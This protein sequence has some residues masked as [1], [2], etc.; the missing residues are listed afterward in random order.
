MRASAVSSLPSKS[1]RFAL[2]VGVDKYDDPQV[3][4]LGG[5]SNDARQ[6]AGALVRH[7]GFPAD[8]VVLLASG[9]PPE[10]Q[11]TR[12]QILRRLSNLA[13]AVPAD[14][15]L[16][17]SF[18]GHGMERGG[19]A[20]L[21]SSD[22][23][24]NGDV[25]LL[26]MTAVNA[27]Q[28]RDRIQKTGVRQVLMLLDACR[29]DPVAARSGADNPLTESLRRAFDFDL[30]NRGVEAFATI[31]ATAVGQ[32]AYEY[33]EKNQGYFT[34]T[35]VEGL[36]GAAADERGE[37]TLAGLV[38]FLQERVPKQ[39]A[40]D[41]GPDKVQRPF[42][43]IEGYRADDLVI[44]VP[45]RP[46]LAN[47]NGA[48]PASGATSQPRPL[49]VEADSP[50]QTSENQAGAQSQAADAQRSAKSGRP[51]RKSGRVLLLIQGGKEKDGP[52]LRAL[53][54]KLAARGLSV[55]AGEEI[56]PSDLARVSGALRR[57][58]AGDR[59]SGDRVPF[60]LV[61]TGE[62]GVSTLTPFNGLFVSAAEGSLKAIDADTGKAVAVE[63]ITGARGFGN[64][65]RQ[66]DDNALAAACEKLSAEFL[67][68]V[69]AAAR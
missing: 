20:Y 49:R 64:T 46:E 12:A 37:V 8:Q 15:L 51:E 1:K 32:R 10:R 27:A 25:D 19:Q 5:A 44:A 35:L 39:V 33:K 69:A 55:T 66:A 60:A 47:G 45:A 22:A 2:V 61:V 48:A 17:F 28:V 31:Y 59:K 65:Q 67:E 43:D 36:K 63:N 54:Q 58:Q 38:K 40:L 4:T 62:V 30:R 57:L 6:L 41:L 7:A 23:Q 14:G 16:L 29:D 26:E 21:L 11:P 18:A 3:T 56:S 24:V 34:W 50:A 53:A 13:A 9:E 52:F 68:R 42:A